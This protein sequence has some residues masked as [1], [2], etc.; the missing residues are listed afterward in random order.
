[1]TDRPEYGRGPMVDVLPAIREAQALDRRDL[2]A[3]AEG[4]DAAKARFFARRRSVFKL[5]G[6]E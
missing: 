5:M 6:L 1:M 2:V 3:M 4:D